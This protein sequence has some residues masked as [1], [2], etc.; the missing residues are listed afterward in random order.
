MYR[1]EHLCTTTAA[2]GGEPDDDDAP[3]MD[4]AWEGGILWTVKA[5]PAL[6]ATLGGSAPTLSEPGAARGGGDGGQ[7]QAT[8]I[9]NGIPRPP[10]KMVGRHAQMRFGPVNQRKCFWKGSN[11][12][13]AAA[14]LSS[15]AFES[16]SWLSGRV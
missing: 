11:K 2:F 9:S 12:V 16:L 13:Q 1:S 3:S 10:P 8:A 5:V 14:P 4:G 15:S 7:G 6:G